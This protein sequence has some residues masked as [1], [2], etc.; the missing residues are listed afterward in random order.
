VI[1]GEGNGGV[2]DPRVGLVRDSFVGMALVLDAMAKGAKRI[3]E[4]ADELPQY[5]IHKTA[6]SVDPARI[7]AALDALERRFPEAEP[8]RLDGLRLDFPSKA[9]LLVRPSNTEPIIRAI[10]EAATHQEARQLCEAAAEAI[11]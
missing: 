2:I 10:A 3:S 4:L 11:A 1:G 7:P 6:I 9:W 5:A 8:D